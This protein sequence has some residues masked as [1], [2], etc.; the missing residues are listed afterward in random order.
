VTAT[1]N[2]LS[3]ILRQLDVKVMAVVATNHMDLSKVVK[4]S[5]WKLAHSLLP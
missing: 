5:K 2:I 4:P 1:N 3:E